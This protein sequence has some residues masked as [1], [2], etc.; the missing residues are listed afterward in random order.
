MLHKNSESIRQTSA[1]LNLSNS[2]WNVWR[3]IITQ[4]ELKCSDI[5][6]L[7]KSSI[8]D[9]NESGMVCPYV[10]P[11][12]LFLD[13]YICV[14][15]S[16]S[17]SFYAIK[18]WT[19]QVGC[20]ALLDELLWSS[21]IMIIDLWFDFCCEINIFVLNK[22]NLRRSIGKTAS[23]R[24]NFKGVH[25]WQGNAWA[26]AELE[27]R[28]TQQTVSLSYC[29]VSNYMASGT[30]WFAV[31]MYRNCSMSS[32]P[33]FAC[34]SMESS[35]IMHLTNLLNCVCRWLYV[36]EDDI[37]NLPCFQVSSF[38]SPKLC[39]LSLG[40]NCLGWLTIYQYGIHGH[41]PYT[42]FAVWAY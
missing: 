18:K 36:T 25:G 37:K 41:L 1:L 16:W 15:I 6:V 4:C 7:M 19:I 42:Y 24:F 32:F 34:Y 11:Y 8:S 35:H 20:G 12:L 22:A 2:G 5:W 31:F 30:H 17:S 14:Q 40:L 13:F 9:F 28:R 33:S 23:V 38:A 3:V 21:A 29:T 10:C 26:V 27:W 39:M